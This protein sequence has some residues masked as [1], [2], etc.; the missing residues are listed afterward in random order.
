MDMRDLSHKDKHEVLL[1]LDVEEAAH[2]EVLEV[3]VL[4]I[5][6]LFV[7]GL[8]K[9]F[10]AENLEGWFAPGAIE[11]VNHDVLLLDVGFNF[12]FEHLSLKIKENA[13]MIAQSVELEVLAEGPLVLLQEVFLLFDG[14]ARESVESVRVEVV[15]KEKLKLTLRAF[16]KHSSVEDD[17]V[18]LVVE[19]TQIWHL[20]FGLAREDLLKEDLALFGKLRVHHKQGLRESMHSLL[21]AYGQLAPGLKE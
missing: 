6:E 20:H 11:L 13:V 12:I 14:E 10:E 9:V 1:S 8:A 2:Q 5:L 15:E 4:E 3:L 21:W 19:G 17:Q 16:A 7:D 18:I